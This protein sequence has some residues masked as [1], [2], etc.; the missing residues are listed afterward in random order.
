MTRQKTH[1]E[2]Y[3]RQYEH[4]LCGQRVRVVTHTGFTTT[5]TVRR[6]M[7]TTF[8]LLATETGD[9]AYLVSDCTPIPQ[10]PEREN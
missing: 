6:V 3:P 10:S 1:R 8:G 4:P 5:M 7:S 9:V 2:M